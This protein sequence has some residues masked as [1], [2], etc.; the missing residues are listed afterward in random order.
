MPRNTTGRT[1]AELSNANMQHQ[2]AYKTIKLE[3]GATMS[4]TDRRLET[5]TAL[6]RP[7]NCNEQVNK[8]Q[9]L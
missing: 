8:P 9:D 1:L 6:V 7:D 3:S 4:E 2:G 5:L